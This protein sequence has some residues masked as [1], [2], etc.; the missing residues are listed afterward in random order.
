MFFTLKLFLH[1]HHYS[2]WGLNALGNTLQPTQ[3]THV[4][5]CTTKLKH[6][7]RLNDKSTIVILLEIGKFDIGLFQ[8]HVLEKYLRGL[9]Q[10]QKV[11]QYINFH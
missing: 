5:K 4:E 1:H 10:I 11:H 8:R 7:S 9:S 2:T 6:R 3:H